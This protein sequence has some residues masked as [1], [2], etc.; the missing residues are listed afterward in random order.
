MSMTTFALIALLK[1]AEMA[2]GLPPGLLVG[3]CGVESEY[4]AEAL[5]PADGGSASVGLCQIKHKTAVQF[6]FKGTEAQLWHSP[7]LN[8]KYAAKYLRH[9]L[10]RYAGDPAL[11]V[12]AYNAGHASSKNTKYT[13]KVL[14]RWKGYQVY[15]CGSQALQE[16]H[17]QAREICLSAWP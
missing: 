15:A 2:H 12:S 6:G 14:S 4:N 5:H 3:L 9:Q 17:F 10:D 1:T 8:A 13:H 16:I 11:A 7:A